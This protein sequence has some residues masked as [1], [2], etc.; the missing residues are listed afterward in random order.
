MHYH[1]TVRL[2]TGRHDAPADGMCVMELS[3]LLAGERFS[4]QPTTVDPVIAALLRIV[5]DVMDGEERRRLIPYASRVIGTAGGLRARRARARI[6]ARYVGRR[7]VLRPEP[8]G[9]RAASR[10]LRRA[11]V[12]GVLALC[13]ELI[14]AGPHLPEPDVAVPAARPVSAVGG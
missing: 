6:C 2:S 13:D 14:A 10:A 4:D 11:D 3:S 7:L 9:A 1:Q 8:W 5:N 12:D